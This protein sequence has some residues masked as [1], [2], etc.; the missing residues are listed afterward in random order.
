MELADRLPFCPRCAYPFTGLPEAHQCPE[1]GLPYDAESRMWVG[2]ARRSPPFRII[3]LIFGAFI[4]LVA[5]AMI[6]KGPSSLTRMFTGPLNLVIGVGNFYLGFRS[7]K[8][9]VPFLAILPN[10]VWFLNVLGKTQSIPWSRI[11]KA[12][13]RWTPFGALLTIQLKRR[14]QERIPQGLTRQINVPAAIALI[15]A[16]VTKSTA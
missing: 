16:R 5:I 12:E 8:K 6:I 1:C 14:G 15:N 13:D 11:Q 4:A 10:G 2:N 9:Y 3:Q 7:L